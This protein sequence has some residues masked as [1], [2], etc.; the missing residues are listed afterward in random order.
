[1]PL[2]RAQ[3]HFGDMMQCYPHCW[4]AYHGVFT[5]P[6]EDRFPNVRQPVLLITNDGSLKEETEAAL[7]LFPQAQLMHISG[8]TLGGF[9]LA[10]DKYVAAIRSLL[11][12]GPGHQ[13]KK[14]K[15]MDDG[16]E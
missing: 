10:P 11:D 15:E 7:P 13:D 14:G 12:S 3:E 8:V 5:Y 2:E 6:S 9:D 1:M 16:R 4:E